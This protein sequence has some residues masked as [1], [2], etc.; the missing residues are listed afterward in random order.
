M[1]PIDG[2]G[3]PVFAN[4]TLPE[5]R[6]LM[7]IALYKAGNGK[8]YAIAGRKTGPTDGSYLAQYELSDDGKGKVQANEVRRF[9]KFSGKNEIEAIYV[10]DVAGYVYYCDEGVGIRKYFADPAKGNE[11]LALFG[12]NGFTED[13]EG[14]SMYATSDSTGFILVSDQQAQ[15]F[16]IFTREGTKGNPHDHVFLK[17]VKVSALESDGSEMTSVPLG[18]FRKGLFVAMSTD[19][20]FHYFKAEDIL[21]DLLKQ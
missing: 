1:Q 13:H 6:D 21:G 12:T 11:E 9:G 3:L 19:R 15:S 4:D 2:G 5:Y 17:S 8:I 10:D 7:G 18:E 16:R 20:T 14:I